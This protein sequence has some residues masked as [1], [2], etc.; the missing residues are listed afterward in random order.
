ML[1]SL[2]TFL[3]T[4]P[5]HEL[6]IGG[7][8][9]GI[10]EGG[11]SEEGSIA[12]FTAECGVVDIHADLH[13]GTFPSTYDRGSKRIDQIYV[14]DCLYTDNFIH[15]STIGGYD[16]I[17]PSDHC[18]L[19]L[20]FD[21][22]GFFDAKSFTAQP[23]QARILRFT[24]P[25]LTRK[26]LEHALDGIS[27]QKLDTKLDILAHRVCKN[28]EFTRKDETEMNEIDEALTSILLG[29]ERCIRPPPRDNRTTIC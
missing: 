1:I 18:P 17:C 21:A 20:D 23:H 24:D 25:R 28:G 29:A 9:N 26:Y 14:S 15:T 22:R 13:T 8:F 10:D 16:S 3:S 19:F 12:W 27:S 4:Y 7:D 2:T 5:N 11:P 6:I